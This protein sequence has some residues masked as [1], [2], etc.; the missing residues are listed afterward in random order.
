MW[1][2]PWKTAWGRRKANHQKNWRSPDQWQ[3]SSLCMEQDPSEGGGQDTSAMRDLAKVREA[4]WRALA[5]TAALEEKIERLNWSITRGWPDACAH[6][7]SCD[8][9]REKVPGT[10]Q[11]MLQG[12]ARGQPCPFP[13]AQPSLVG[14]RNL[15]G[16]RG[17]TALFW[18]LTWGCHQSWN[19]MLTT[20]FSRSQPTVQGKKAEMI[21]PQNPQQRN[22]RDQ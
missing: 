8:C 6:S 2:P 7:Q 5:T 22:M 13:W 11:E 18:N 9:Q 17:W 1:C 16:W 12:F 10:K 19:Q 14:P 3:M 4:H 20:A 21:P 15:G